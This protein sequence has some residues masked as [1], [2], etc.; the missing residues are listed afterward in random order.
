MRIK[1]RIKAEVELSFA[2]FVIQFWQKRQVAHGCLGSIK[3]DFTG[4]Y[5]CRPYSVITLNSK[6][7]DSWTRKRCKIP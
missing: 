3:Y 5:Y 4:I 6:D 1:Y 7:L 2:D